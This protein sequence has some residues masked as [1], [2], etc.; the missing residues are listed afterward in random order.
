MYETKNP[1][2]EPT[3]PI[4]IALM[5]FLTGLLP[6]SQGIQPYAKDQGVP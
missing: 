3:L 2:H 4:N 5:A 6:A 1:K